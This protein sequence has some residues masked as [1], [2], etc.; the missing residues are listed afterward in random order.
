MDIIKEAREMK[1]LLFFELIKIYIN[2]YFPLFLVLLLQFEIYIPFFPNR[3]IFAD[4]IQTHKTK[5][6]YKL[7]EKHGLANSTCLIV[8]GNNLSF[9]FLLDLKLLK[10]PFHF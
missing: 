6:F 3:N 8:D 2:I 10:N 7:L 5:D 9:R 1:I 4:N